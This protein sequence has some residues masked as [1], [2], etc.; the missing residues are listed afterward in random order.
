[1]ISVAEPLAGS[2]IAAD[3]VEILDRLLWQ[4]AQNM[5]ARHTAL[6]GLGPHDDSCSWCGHAWPCPPRRLAERAAAASTRTWQQAWTAR[7][8]L[9]GL[10]SLPSM[11]TEPG[12]RN[13]GSLLGLSLEGIG[14]PVNKGLFD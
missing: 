13:A 14:Q 6:D 7:H 1:M 5:L 3:G 9:N 2:D 12:P 4:D 10:R 8:D 11:R